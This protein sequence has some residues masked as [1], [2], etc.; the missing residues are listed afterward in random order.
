MEVESACWAASG[1]AAGLVCRAV[2]ANGAW[3][4]MKTESACRAGPGTDGPAGLV[5]R[6]GDDGAAGCTP[7]CGSSA[8]TVP[9]GRP[10]V[11]PPGSP[12]GPPVGWNAPDH[13]S[14]AGFRSGSGLN[15]KGWRPQARRPAGLRLRRSWAAARTHRG[16][17]RRRPGGGAGPVLRDGPRAGPC[18]RRPRRRGRAGAAGPAQRVP[19]A[20]RAAGHRAQPGRRHRHPTSGGRPRP[21]NGHAH[22]G[23]SAQAEPADP[24]PRSPATPTPRATGQT[25]THAY[26]AAHRGG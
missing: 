23:R 7:G 25:R 4:A 24:D 8:S 10:P 20:P 16:W 9:A 26:S 6:L 17:A 11:R 3:P 22:A 2:P 19:G 12:P 18:G 5:V 13:E 1:R 15:R 14:L 21:A